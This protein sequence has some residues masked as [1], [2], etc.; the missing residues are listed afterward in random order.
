MPL[1][2][3]LHHP[4]PPAELAGGAL[5]RA[6]RHDDLLRPGDLSGLLRRARGDQVDDADGAHRLAVARYVARP[7]YLAA[8]ARLQRRLKLRTEHR[9]RA[10]L[11]DARRRPDVRAAVEHE[12]RRAEPP[13]PQPIALSRP[14]SP[15]PPHPP[16]PLS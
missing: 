9:L 11:G 12:L 14:G 2:L 1:D 15:M 8:V 16:R 13:D 7:Q 10:V 3:R 5:L 4:G 6:A